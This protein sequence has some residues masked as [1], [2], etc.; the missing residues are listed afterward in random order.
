MLTNCS[1][2]DANVSHGRVYETCVN[3]LQTLVAFFSAYTVHLGGGESLS[4]TGALMTALSAL[5]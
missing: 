1:R 4:I 2:A 3:T 5:L